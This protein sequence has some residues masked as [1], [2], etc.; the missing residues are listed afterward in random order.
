MQT[1]A[2]TCSPQLDENPELAQFLGSKAAA[3]AGIEVVN[4][5]LDPVRAMSHGINKLPAFVAKTADGKV[6]GM[7]TGFVGAEWTLEWVAFVKGSVRVTS[8]DIG[9]A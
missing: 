7:T 4:V 5:E 8:G 6:L 2:F 1:L 3:D 9:H